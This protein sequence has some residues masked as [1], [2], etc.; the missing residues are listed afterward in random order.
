MKAQLVKTFIKAAAIVALATSIAN[1]G[2]MPEELALQIEP[3]HEIVK[4]C[5]TE[6]QTLL[7]S[8][9]MGTKVD[10]LIKLSLKHPVKVHVSTKN[11]QSK[12]DSGGIEVAN[13]LEQEFVRV[14]ASN[15][16]VNREAMLLAL[17]TRT[18]TSRTI[19]FFDTKVDARCS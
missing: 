7:F 3:L 2:A 19:V 18:F 12:G 5:P 6:R 17:L 4:A 13:R 9:T 8:A 14:R 11:Y 1:C 16:G 10:D 15:E